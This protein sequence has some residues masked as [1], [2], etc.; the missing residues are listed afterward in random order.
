MAALAETQAVEV[1]KYVL[2][3]AIDISVCTL[4]SLRVSTFI[5]SNFGA[6]AGG[7]SIAVIIGAVVGGVAL[8]AFL[9]LIVVRTF[10]SL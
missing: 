5:M 4:A 3:I 9:A 2:L 6:F 8:V 7:L 10:H 1:R